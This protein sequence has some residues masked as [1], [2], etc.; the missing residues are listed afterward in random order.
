MNLGKK[1]GIVVVG[2][3]QKRE[4]MPLTLELSEMI[5]ITFA[6]SGPASMILPTSPLP[7]MTFISTDSPSFV[8]LLMV[9]EK[10]SL[11]DK[12]FLQAR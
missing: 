1:E 3:I 7:A 4:I 5:A 8:P 11:Q 2:E 6:Q 9:K 10:L 12:S